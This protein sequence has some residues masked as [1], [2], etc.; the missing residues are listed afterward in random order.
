[1]DYLNWRYADPRAGRFR[2]RLAEER[3]RL[4]GYSVL[5]SMRGHGY[6]ADLLTLPGREDVAESLLRDAFAAFRDADLQSGRCWAPH[7]HPYLGALQ[8]TGFT[9]HRQPRHV[10]YRV[11]RNPEQAQVLSE[12][13]ARVHLMIGDSD[14]V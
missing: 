5:T 14:N 9:R 13:D 1:M 2:I 3:G 7:A 6:I 4:L 12:P 8:R 10:T 11:H